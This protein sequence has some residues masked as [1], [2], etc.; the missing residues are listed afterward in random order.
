MTFLNFILADVSTASSKF[1]NI[2]WRYELSIEKKLLDCS[3]F[4][5]IQV[6]R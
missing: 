4:V 1:E 2:L 3:L 5:V 6:R